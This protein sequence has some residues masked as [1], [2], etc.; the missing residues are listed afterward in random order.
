MTSDQLAKWKAAD[1]AR[2][3]QQRN[4]RGRRKRGLATVTGAGM[5]ALV[6]H[7]ARTRR[8]PPAHNQHREDSTMTD[9]EII[10]RLHAITD[11]QDQLVS[12]LGEGDYTETRAALD[13]S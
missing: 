7:P 12:R 5:G 4:Q 1:R 3:R 10:K 9:I 13:G 6:H 8:R 11:E 2:K